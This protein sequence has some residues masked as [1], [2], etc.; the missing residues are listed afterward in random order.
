MELSFRQKEP[1]HDW[2][3]VLYVKGGCVF[4]SGLIY[5]VSLRR[6]RLRFRNALHVGGDRDAGRAGGVGR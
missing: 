6:I 1:F 2:I 3:K 5:G 4:C